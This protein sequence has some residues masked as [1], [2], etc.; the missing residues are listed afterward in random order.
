MATYEGKYNHDVDP[1]TGQYLSSP[2]SAAM[3]FATMLT[4]E[5]HVPVL[6]N[7]FRPSITLDLNL[8]GSNRVNSSNDDKYKE[9]RIEDY[10]PSLGKYPNFTLY[11]FQ[12]LR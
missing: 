2:G 10:V 11:K 4:S 8:S 1:T 7:P 12:N 5:F 3:I 6:D 9:K